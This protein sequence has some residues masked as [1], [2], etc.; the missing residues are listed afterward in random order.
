MKR[1]NRTHGDS[2]SA[3][4]SESFTR[5]GESCS[6]MSSDCVKATTTDESASRIG[7]VFS[8][9]VGAHRS[10]AACHLK[11]SPRDS[12]KDQLKLRT[13]PWLVS[14]RKYRTRGSSEA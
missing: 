10:S 6:S 2:S 7:T 4:T 13:M 9:K 14:E 5:L 8:R 12:S 1:L 11:Y 3:M